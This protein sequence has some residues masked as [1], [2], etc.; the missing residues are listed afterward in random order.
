[1]SILQV[2]APTLEEIGGMKPDSTL[3]SY[4]YPSQNPD[5]LAQLSEK[6]LTVFA[7]DQVPRVTIAQ[8]NSCFNPCLIVG[9]V[10]LLIVYLMMICGANV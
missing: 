4:I 8:V 7:M 3:F 9:A 5:L 10:A 1:M 6:N 2:R